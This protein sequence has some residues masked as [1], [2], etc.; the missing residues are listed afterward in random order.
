MPAELGLVLDPAASDPNGDAAAV[1]V[2]AAP[3]VVIAL[4]GVQLLRPAPWP[5]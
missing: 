2:G 4:V 1:Q 5:P 3:L